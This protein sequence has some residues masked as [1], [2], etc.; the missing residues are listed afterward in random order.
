VLREAMLLHVGDATDPAMRLELAR[1]M[2]QL[3]ALGRPEPDAF[4]RAFAAEA[5]EVLRRGESALFHDYLPEVYE[6][7]YL[8]DFVA[9]AAR[10]QLQYLT[11]AGVMDAANPNVSPE[12]MAAVAKSAASRVEREQYLDILRLRRF[13]QS[14]VCRAEVALQ[15][16]WDGSRV[17]GLYAAAACQ[18]TGEGKFKGQ[19][20]VTIETSHPGVI[21]FLRK[22]IA[23]WPQAA[24][25]DSEEADM[26]LP[27]FRGSMVELRTTPGIAVRAGERPMASPLARYQCRRGDVEMSTLN[28]R[29]LPIGGEK[30]R[31]FL[32]LLDGTRDRAALARDAGITLQEVDQPLEE[33]GRF[34]MLVA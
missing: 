13:R 33:L 12:V 34:A 23:I 19:S 11:D 9:H 7:A 3:F 1:S 14:L 21:A 24:K 31:R 27:L 18:E 17:A 16:E 6:P 29:S 20:G 10:H 15:D 4:D 22:R 26:A 25:L 5:A 8:R 2:L 28:H 30:A 32:E